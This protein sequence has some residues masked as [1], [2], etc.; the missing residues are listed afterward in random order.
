MAEVA[1]TEE[2][3]VR[4][5]PALRQV[6][7][8][9]PAL[10][11]VLE[12]LLAE[13]LGGAFAR[14]LDDAP[15]GA[16]S[17][18]LR[19]AARV[20]LDRV[21]RHRALLEEEAVETIGPAD[22]SPVPLVTLE[23]QQTRQTSDLARGRA[24][25]ADGAWASLAFAGGAGTR[26]FSRLDELTAALPRP[27]EVLRARSFDHAEPKGVFPISPVRGLSF[28]QLIV[29][30][31]LHCGFLY[32]RLPRVLLL[33]SAVTHDRT[34]R[35]LRG[36][37]LWGFPDDGWIAFQQAREPRLDEHGDL[38]AE[39]HDG[40]L[41]WTGDGHGGVYRALLAED[42]APDAHGSLLE[43]LRGRGVGHLVMHNVDNPVARPFEPARLGFHL[44]EGALFTISAVRKTDPAEKVGL[45]MRMKA[46][47]RVEVVEYNVLD[48][49]VAG[50][51]DPATGRLL[52]EAGNTNTNL[53]A[54]EAIRTDIDPTI[55]RGKTVASRRGPVSASSMEML[56]QHITRKLDPDRVRAYEVARPDFFMPTKNVT[57]VDSVASTT[58]MLSGLYADRL[59]AA[60]AEVEPQAL[61]DLH[62]A[63]DRP[64]EL[65]I[66]EGW[67]LE[68]GAR[69][70]L[71]VRQGDP[72]GAPVSDGALRL[73]PDST[74]IL[75][76]ARP[77]GHID[78]DQARRLTIAAEQAS[79]A[80][81][82]RGV[83]IRRGVRVIVRIGPGARLRIPDGRDFTE[84]V[85]CEI[86][87]GR[88][89][90]L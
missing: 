59:R 86:A 14:Y 4:A 55:Y 78:T 75:D 1:M 88:E 82:G 36:H 63:C 79:C 35:Y 87:P 67:C 7:E 53:V 49:A 5:C 10:R 23:Q 15:A 54:L 68:A 3:A 22:V 18:F 40:H 38:I 76:A 42:N 12:R 30:E 8:R 80:R 69:L 70:F 2:E 50:A 51:R 62:P 64:G 27:N 25:L 85:E 39:D 41:S 11:P 71:G 73:E 20:D 81:I 61:C 84:D 72:A 32:G 33:T 60:G 46:G 89:H 77:Y 9:E 66:G 58:R 26:F 28:Y 74:L 13:D 17:V 34:V 83:T 21:R 90:V 48:P 52:H 56:N 29:A 65:G 57:G 45:L 43:A 31:A 37:D 19:E 24:S 47:S 44:E 16:V 6:L